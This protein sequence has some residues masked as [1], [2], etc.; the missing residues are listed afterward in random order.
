MESPD[1]RR[2]RTAATRDPATDTPRPERL[3]GEPRPMPQPKQPRTRNP[4]TDTPR[5]ERLNGEPRPMPQPN[6]GTG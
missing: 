1:Q 5:P 3:N 6:A 4:A 2:N